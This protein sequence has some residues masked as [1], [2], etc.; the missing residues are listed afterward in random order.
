MHLV[1]L[2]LL[3]RFS[4]EVLWCK[5]CFKNLEVV[6]PER[7]LFDAF[8]C[9]TCQTLQVHT[10]RVYGSPKGEWESRFHHLLLSKVDDGI[11]LHQM[12]AVCLN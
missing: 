4:F 1:N 8:L 7:T 9:L 11:E 3:T 6:W 2:H 12:L 5:S 10:R